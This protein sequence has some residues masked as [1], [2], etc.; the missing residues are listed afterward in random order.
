MA[1]KVMAYTCSRC[2][3]EW[4]VPLEEGEKGS[5]PASMELE[6]GRADGSSVGVSYAELCTT[7]AGVVE[8]YVKH[9]GR[10]MTHK[11]PNRAKEK[12]PGEAPEGT[13]PE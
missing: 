9:I 3:R 10:V 4:F 1:K 13:P 7:C 8:S 2:A 12:N 5:P 11:S 6:F